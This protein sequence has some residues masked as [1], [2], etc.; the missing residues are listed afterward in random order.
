MPSWF[1]SVAIG[2]RIRHR[3]WM[4][5]MARADLAQSV[6]INVDVLEHFEVGLGLMDAR[7]LEA[8]AAVLTVPLADLS[9]GVPGQF[10]HPGTHREFRIPTALG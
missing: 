5:G 6:G 7:H 2:R 8:I 4:L 9:Q 1:D 3:R 10:A